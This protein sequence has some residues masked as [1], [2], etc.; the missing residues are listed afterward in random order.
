MVIDGLRRD[1]QMR[2]DLGVGVPGTD[3][4]ETL[5]LALGEPERMRTG[6]GLRSDRNRADAQAAHL[7]PGDARWSGR[8]EPGEYGQCLAQRLLIGRAE[9][10]HGGLVRAAKLGP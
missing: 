7:L 1:E 9:Q 6:R 4:V 5:T 3:Q 10:I 2:G 8:A